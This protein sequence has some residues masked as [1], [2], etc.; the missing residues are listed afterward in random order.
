[1][2]AT[3]ERGPGPSTRLR[4]RPTAGRQTYGRCWYWMG[5]QYCT[6]LA[7]LPSAGDLRLFYRQ[8]ARD[9]VV[10]VAITRLSIDVRRPRLVIRLGRPPLRRGP[11]RARRRRRRCGTGRAAAEGCSPS[12]CRPRRETSP[13]TARARRR[14]D[15]RSSANAGLPHWPGRP[16]APCHHPCRRFGRQGGSRPR[17]RGL[18][19]PEAQRGQFGFVGVEHGAG[20]QR[21][22]PVAVGADRR[23]T[24]R[25]GLSPKPPADARSTDARGRRGWRTGP[26]GWRG[27]G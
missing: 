16:T 5:I 2:I 3:D 21:G 9:K 11:G 4:R 22:V 24:H 14:A 18:A 8:V 19:V 1:M 17:P 27:P 13:S 12:R 10:V 6:G 15:V 26:P 25:H 20:G 7:G 23:L